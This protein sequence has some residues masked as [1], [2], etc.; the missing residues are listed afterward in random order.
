MPG[1]GRPVIGGD[2]AD[3]WLKRTWWL[4]F[5]SFTVLTVRLDVE[6]ACADPYD[7]LPALASEP[8]WA[9]PVALVYVL[10]HFWAVA[11]YLLTVSRTQEMVPPVRAWQSVWG[12]EVAKPI[13]M[14]AV[15]IAEYVPVQVWRLIGTSLRCTY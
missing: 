15:L 11:A 14:A 2:F 8:A 10:A 4:L 13:V 12:T 7:L 9:W 6:R 5:P 3:K 1:D